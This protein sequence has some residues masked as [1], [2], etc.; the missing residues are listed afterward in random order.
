MSCRSEFLSE[1]RPPTRAVVADASQ[2]R[3]LYVQPLREVDVAELLRRVEVQEHVANVADAVMRMG[4]SQ[5]LICRPVTLRMAA[6]IAVHR[7]CGLREPPDAS[8]VEC[9]TYEGSVARLYQEYLRVTAFAS[10]MAT[11]AEYRAML[12][13]LEDAALT[14]LDAG[15]WQLTFSAM[16]S[17]LV[18]HSPGPSAIDR[19][20]QCAPLR[21]ESREDYALCS[22][23]HK[24]VAEYLCATAHWSRTH[25]SLC[26]VGRSWT[27]QEPGILA[28]IN[29]L[30]RTSTAE[31]DRICGLSILTTIRQQQSSV[32][33]GAVS[34]N[35][36]A[37]MAAANYP[38]QCTDLSHLR[39]AEA[40]LVHADFEGA[41]L[42][43]TEF[44]NCDL[45]SANFSYANVNSIVFENCTYANSLPPLEGHT[46]CVSSVCFSPDGRQ[47]AS[48]SD[49]KSV[50]V[51]DLSSGR[52]VKKL[53]GHT[54]RV[55]SVCFSP[56]G[57]QLASGSDDKSVRVWDLVEWARSEE[58]RG[59]HRRRQ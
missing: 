43:H 41:N 7:L 11:A 6:S 25:A 26:H 12:W 15:D 16:K 3:A 56:D 5:E 53:E 34:S 49:D 32:S 38:M 42:A 44:R 45:H 14:M 30:S 18:V 17:I 51:W 33:S 1:V 20:F 10:G 29:D 23:T 28:F 22:F 48:G 58:A 9:T 39:I 24:S 59:A 21:F 46:D 8:S 13:G 52:E 47:L 36:V 50:R 31:R 27:R 55:S 2:C 57:R 54:E 40:N 4:I 35:G 37:I 19:I